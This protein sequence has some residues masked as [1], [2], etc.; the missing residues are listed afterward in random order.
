M[1]CMNSIKKEDFGFIKSI[2]FA[3]HFVLSLSDLTTF[4]NICIC[5]IW[6]IHFLERNGYIPSFFWS[7]LSKEIPRIPK[8]TWEPHSNST[9]IR[10]SYEVWEWYGLFTWD[11]GARG[12]AHN[13]KM[14]IVRYSGN[15]WLPSNEPKTLQQ[16]DTTT[17]NLPSLGKLEFL[18]L[19][20]DV[21]FC[22]A[23]WWF[24]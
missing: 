2:T 4:V 5:L 6:I 22:T 21:R 9:P 23:N 13:T 10:I 16:L 3:F 15:R 7:K 20:G 12:P 19:V 14:K 1:T 18:C 11:T 24:F 8:S 17:T